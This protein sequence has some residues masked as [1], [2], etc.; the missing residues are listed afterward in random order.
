MACTRDWLGQLSVARAG[1]GPPL[2]LLH[3]GSGPLDRAPFFAKLSESFEVIAPTHPGFAATRLP[4][5]CDT[6]DDLAYL[7]L[8]LM[9]SLDLRDAVLMGFSMGGWVAAEIAVKSTAR[10]AR[11]ILVDAVGIKVGDRETRDI[12]DLFIR[13]QDEINRLVFHDPASAPDPS[14]MSEED[15]RHQAYNRQ[16]LALYGWEPYLHN[17]KLAGRLHRVDVPTLLIWG[18]SDGVVTPEY[19]A[20]YR[21]LIPEAQLVVIPE[22]GHVPQIEQADA[23][24]GHVLG[25][26]RQAPR[27]DTRE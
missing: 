1:A 10:L 5:D 23:F 8:D 6:V 21:D 11:L 2:L 26:A 15:Q 24:V 17:P 27:F 25:F 16:S 13:S 22:A 3:G 4:D 18:E 14:T 9:A 19:G 12:A 20:A 7:Y